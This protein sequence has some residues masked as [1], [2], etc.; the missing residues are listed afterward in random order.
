[1]YFVRRYRLSQRDRGGRLLVEQLH[2][3]NLCT[4]VNLEFKLKSRED[5]HRY[6]EFSRVLA[7]ILGLDAL[8]IAIE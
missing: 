4:N 5:H 7:A 6:V 8:L 2:G 1:M 3:L